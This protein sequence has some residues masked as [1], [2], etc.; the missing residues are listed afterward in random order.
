MIPIL[1]ALQHLYSRPQLR[2]QALELVE[3]DVLGDAAPDQGRPGL[4]LWQILVLA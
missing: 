2:R 4:T 1:R 3:K